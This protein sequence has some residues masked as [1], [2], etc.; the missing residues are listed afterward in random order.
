LF[1]GEVNFKVG[2]SHFFPDSWDL[3]A[4][5]FTLPTV[6]NGVVLKVL[7]QGG[8]GKYKTMKT[9]FSLNVERN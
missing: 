7:C 8:A 4:G 2:Q 6:S 1:F 9:S 3:F 5:F